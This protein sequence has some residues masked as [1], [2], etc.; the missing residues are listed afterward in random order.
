[1]I[2]LDSLENS[3]LEAVGAEEDQSVLS[4]TEVCSQVSL[5][6]H[7]YSRDLNLSIFVYGSVHGQREIFKSVS[8]SWRE[9]FLVCALDLAGPLSSFSSFPI[10]LYFL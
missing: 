5:L 3:A 6:V 4:V 7:L 2:F 9:S 1:M 8:L 10:F